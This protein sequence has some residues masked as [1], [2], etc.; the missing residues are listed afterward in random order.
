MMT[1]GY[2]EWLLAVVFQK[3]IFIKFLEN[4]EIEA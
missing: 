2:K 3:K 4:F 1:P